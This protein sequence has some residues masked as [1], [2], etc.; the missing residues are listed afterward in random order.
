VVLALPLAALVALPLLPAAGVLP[1]SYEFVH[2]GVLIVAG[3]VT[4][5]AIPT[6]V[7]LI[8]INVLALLASAALVLRRQRLLRSTDVRL[9]L[10][11]WHLRSLVPEAEDV[12]HGP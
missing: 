3:P 4:F 11:L 5:K 7:F 2:G 10:L 8:L 9:R 1:P 6:M 12:A